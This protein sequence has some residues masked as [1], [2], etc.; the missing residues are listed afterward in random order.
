MNYYADNINTLIILD[1]PSQNKLTQFTITKEKIV[2]KTLADNSILEHIFQQY[3]F[4]KFI[5][6]VEEILKP[7]SILKHDIQR[8]LSDL[9]RTEQ[10]A[11]NFNSNSNFNSDISDLPSNVTEGILEGKI[12]KK[13]MKKDKTGSIDEDDVDSI[14]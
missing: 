7:I 3:Q 4:E 6:Y 14:F 12:D 8:L 9:K 11:N 2:I 13:Y 1:I 10:S 5:D